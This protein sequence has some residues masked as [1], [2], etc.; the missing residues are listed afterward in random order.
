MPPPSIEVEGLYYA[1]EGEQWALEDINL[2]IHAGEFVAIIGQNGSGKTTLVKH[3]DGL[4][5]PKRGVVRV[6]GQDT[7]QLSLAELASQV[8]Y[9]FQNPDHQIFHATVA[10]EIEFGPMHMGVTREEV[11]QHLAD[12]LATVGL[13]GYRDEYPFSLSRGQ[14]QK[15]AVAS[16]LAM[17]PPVIIV[18]EPT[19]GMD[20]RDGVAMMDLIERLNQSGR[21]IVIITHDMRIVASYAKRVIVMRQ[22]KIL[23]DGETREVFSNAAILH[24]SYLLPPQITRLA[25]L[26]ADAGV[27]G[28]SRDILTAAEMAD[29]LTP[30]VTGGNRRGVAL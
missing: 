14:R 2:S 16:I 27:L 4:L 5:K 10:E 11:S 30:L 1:Y 19:T 18:D 12:V 3:F 8:G 22:G 13:E 26:L 21:T 29:A 17:N 28:V 23:A 9:C 15:L 6:H 20:W 25:Q 24:Q 7:S